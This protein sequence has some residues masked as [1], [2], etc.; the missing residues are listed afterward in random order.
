MDA[1]KILYCFFLIPF[2]SSAASSSK[3]CQPSYC[4]VNLVQ[5]PFRLIGLQPESCGSPGFN[6]QC[7]NQTTLLI[8]L[9]KSNNFV[10]QNINY[11]SQTIQIY[12]PLNCLPARFLT[13]NLS[14]SPFSFSNAQ[15]YTLLSCPNHEVGSLYGFTNIYCLSN[16]SYTTL[17]TT[18]SSAVV[19]SIT[20]NYTSCSIFGFIQ[21]PEEVAE[22]RYSDLCVKP[23]YCE[24]PGSLDWYQYED[25]NCKEDSSH[26]QKCVNDITKGWF[27]P[28]LL[29]YLGMLA[30]VIILILL[31]RC[32]NK[33]PHMEAYTIL[34]YVLFI[35]PLLS[36][37]ASNDCT[38]SYC[39]NRSFIGVRFPFRIINQQQ[40]NCGFPG[41][42]LRCVFSNML[43]I[44]LPNSGDFAV[45]SI[46]YLNQAIRIYDPFNCLPARLSS[47]F[48]LSDSPFSTSY[49]Q[50]Y[51]LLS[52]PTSA[53][54]FGFKPI[55][56]LSNS[57][58]SVLATTSEGVVASLTRIQTGC[59]VSR[60]IMMPMA[61]QTIQDAS[62]SQLDHDIT[63]T[64][65][66]PNCESCESFGLSCG[67]ADSSSQKTTCF[68]NIASPKVSSVF[69]IIAFAMAI[70]AIAASLMIACF[71]CTKDRHHEIMR[72]RR[73]TNTSITPV[74][75]VPRPNS[76]INGLDQTTIESY[77]KVVLGES[78]RLPGHD[79]ASC[80]ICL[81]EYHV[82]ET[83]R[84][85]PECLHCFHAECI[86]EWLKMNGTC[87][88]CRNSPSPS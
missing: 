23:P 54:L 86:D 32:R 85:I 8:H 31:R 9:P 64:W 42:N 10:V 6:L 43:L 82:K 77:T 2:L 41:F 33:H 53:P 55:D 61:N 65:D 62:T 87:P 3:H 83:V 34:F 56:C 63:L 46:D 36:S 37:A 48:D 47:T 17:A 21:M 60:T 11:H 5:Y 12:D 1:L 49:F 51:T 14:N 28:H 72:S 69:R 30:L 25:P 22:R 80:P 78:K 19:K 67:Y 74:D 35:I 79:D 76:I 52:C 4:G 27:V 16:S 39:N 26:D 20:R 73:T 44:H 18:S 59:L 66:A 13:F 75:A 71:M 68:S 88:I 58:F 38:T 15:N 40:E 84:C 7:V 70:P 50:N 45:R 57:S 81:S 29:L 24:I